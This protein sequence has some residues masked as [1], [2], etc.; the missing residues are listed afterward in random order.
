MPHG[1]EIPNGISFYWQKQAAFFSL[2]LYKTVCDGER[3]LRSCGFIFALLA[4]P[5]SAV[6]APILRSYGEKAPQ[7]RGQRVRRKDSITIA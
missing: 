5:F 2:T 3:N 6:A 4:Y 1:L 7:D